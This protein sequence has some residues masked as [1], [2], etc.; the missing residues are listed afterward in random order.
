MPRLSFMSFPCD[1]KNLRPE[2]LSQESFAA[3]FSLII[4]I[5]KFSYKHNKNELIW[6]LSGHN[7]W[8]KTLL[9]TQ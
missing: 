4:F 3:E 5:L 7:F 2:L 8:Q 1:L 9:E 6:G